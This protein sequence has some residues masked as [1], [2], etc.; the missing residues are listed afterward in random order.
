MFQH[1]TRIDP[2]LGDTSSRLRLGLHV[3]CLLLR[4]RVCPLP[5]GT[6]VTARGPSHSS[7]TAPPL[8]TSAETLLPARSPSEVP[9]GRELWGDAV[10]SSPAS[11]QSRP[12]G[13]LSPQRCL[14]DSRRTVIIR[15][16]AR[17]PGTPTPCGGERARHPSLRPGGWGKVNFTSC[18][19]RPGPN[20]AFGAIDGCADPFVA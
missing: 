18:P 3:A 8:R 12:A 17:L 4:G 19:G 20:L 1:R 5:A 11:G 14:A 9:S 13:S 16:P 6:P 10:Q 7:S 2:G 15:L